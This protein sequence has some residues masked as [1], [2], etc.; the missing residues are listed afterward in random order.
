MTT[1]LVMGGGIAGPTLA[2]ALQRAGIEPIVFEAYP[3]TTAD[4]GSYFTIT[5][6]GLDVLR[7]LDALHLATAIGIPT[8]ANVLWNERGQRLAAVPLGDPLPDG[9]PSLTIKRSRLG[10]ALQDEAIRRGV[11]IEFDKRL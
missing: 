3:R 8:R 2:L 4:I 7:T 9:T 1:A 10:R 6:N 5:P 11:R